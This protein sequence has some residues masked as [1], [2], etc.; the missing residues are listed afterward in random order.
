MRLLAWAVVLG[1][2]SGCGARSAR[3]D[4]VRDTTSALL[5]SSLP[6]TVALVSG[7]DVSSA[8]PFWYG[9]PG[10][11]FLAR[12]T[13]TTLARRTCDE[14]SSWDYVIAASVEVEDSGRWVHVRLSQATVWQISPDS[15]WHSFLDGRRV[16]ANDFAETVRAARFLDPSG[17]AWE[18]ARF[19]RDVELEVIDEHS[20]VVASAIEAPVDM[21]VLMRLH[22]TP[23]AWVTESV[24][25]S[26]SVESRALFV[27]DS[28]G[29]SA[30]I[31]T[32]P[33]Q[34]SGYSPLGVPHLLASD[35]RESAAQ[36]ERID[37]VPMSWASGDMARAIPTHRV[38]GPLERPVPQLFEDEPLLVADGGAVSV[39]VWDSCAS[40]LRH[41]H[42]RVVVE[43]LISMARDEQE[44]HATSWQFYPASMPPIV[45]ST[46]AFEL[47]VLRQVMSDKVRDDD[48]D[49]CHREGRLVGHATQSRLEILVSE[50]DPSIGYL[51]RR[52]AQLGAG[53]GLDMSIR[54]ADWEERRSSLENRTFD[55]VV[56]EYPDFA[57]PGFVYGGGR[58]PVVGQNLGGISDLRLAELIER[59]ESATASDLRAKSMLEFVRRVEHRRYAL[60]V[61]RHEER[62]SVS[63]EVVG[64]VHFCRYP[65]MVSFAE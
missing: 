15:P 53:I 18:L 43:A 38:G 47:D 40:A 58:T 39:L 19:A 3:P 23:T 60:V 33:Y 52:A 37:I 28:A 7:L 30:W 35:G 61:A 13:G 50:D 46:S 22:A 48:G 27:L 36:F 45:P 12:H 59:I 56:V 24:G 26:A 1:L 62:Y 4:S 64:A 5:P 32:G 55:S 6:A 41:H 44:L 9:E 51:L 54:T 21:D 57:F 10:A 65:R 63:E 2:S 49:A 16:L 8:S 31:G 17:P 42:V 34:Y 25:P 11:E 14:P 20:F 29:E